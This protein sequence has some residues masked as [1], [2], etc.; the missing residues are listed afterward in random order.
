VWVSLYL[1]HAPLFVSQRKPIGQSVNKWQS[2]RLGIFGLTESI[3]GKS[4]AGPPYSFTKR[5]HVPR[6]EKLGLT[7]RLPM[8][9]S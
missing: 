4:Y 8:P 5:M 2:W 9:Q 1:I 3:R 7:Q 6:E